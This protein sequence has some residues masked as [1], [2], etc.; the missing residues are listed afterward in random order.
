MP[1]LHRFFDHLM[2]RFIA[3][4]R[5]LALCMVGLAVFAAMCLLPFAACS[6]KRP[7][8]VFI[9]IDTLRADRLGSYGNQ[10]GLSPFLDSV[11]AKAN[12]FP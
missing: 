3:T 11:A 9:V 5:R 10:R 2:P 4:R 7:N 6:A 8:V 1:V 12:V